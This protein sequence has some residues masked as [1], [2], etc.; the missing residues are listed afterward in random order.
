VK[1]SI[2]HPKNDLTRSNTNPIKKT[3]TF[4][5]KNNIVSS[6]SFDESILKIYQNRKDA[7]KLE[8]T[9]LNEINRKSRS[10]SGKKK[11]VIEKWKNNFEK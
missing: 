10:L 7:N 1:K 9:L 2:F 11:E 8:S 5:S 4:K 6:K 3:S